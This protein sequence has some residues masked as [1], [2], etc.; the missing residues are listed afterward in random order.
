MYELFE[1]SE[2]IEL[3]EY[4]EEPT[5]V[6]MEMANLRGN[7][8]K[9]HNRVP[10]SLFISNKRQ[11]HNA[12]AIRVKVLWNPHKMTSTPDGQLELHGNYEYT[13][14]S[15]KYKP[16]EKEVTLLRDFCKKYKVLFAAI[17]ESKLDPNDFIDYLRGY[18]SFVELLMAFDEVSEKHYYLINHCKTLLALEQCIRNNKIFNL[19]D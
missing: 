8:I 10:F 2:A 3:L 6:L 12:H 17:W 18:K 14:F 5:A 1:I 7:D 16:S 13:V 9:L 11:V 15:H 19:N 4:L